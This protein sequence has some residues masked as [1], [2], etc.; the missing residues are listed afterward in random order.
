FRSAARRRLREYG[1]LFAHGLPPAQVTRSLGAEQAATAG[2]AVVAGS[3][4]GVALALA[5]LPVPSPAGALAGLA[6]A[7]ALALA[8]ALVAAVAR[9][10]PERVDPLRL[11]GLG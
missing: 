9:R 1:G 7:G 10:T 8:A 3:A 11:Q 5:V 6:T 2:V 4:L